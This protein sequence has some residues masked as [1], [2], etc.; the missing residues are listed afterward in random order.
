MTYSVKCAYCNYQTPQEA[1]GR[2]LIRHIELYHAELWRNFQQ[3]P[4][5]RPLVRICLCAW[6]LIPVII[7]LCS[8][9]LNTNS[10]VNSLC[11][12]HV[13]HSLCQGSQVHCSS[14]HNE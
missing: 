1:A 2:T 4:A 10:Q 5:T 12:S 6:A 11:N 13:T 8:N 7:L 3:S 9:F 14:H